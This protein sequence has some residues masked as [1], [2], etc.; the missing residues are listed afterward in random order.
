VTLDREVEI[1]RRHAASVIDDADQPPAAG[2]DRDLDGP[3]PGIDGVLD[4]FLHGRGR[5][6]HDLA[7]RD[8]VD[9][10]GIE[11]ADGGRGGGHG[12]LPPR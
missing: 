9:E 1:V 3:R 6:L 2:L 11:A 7:G 10:H 5:A 8:A 12:H 4:E